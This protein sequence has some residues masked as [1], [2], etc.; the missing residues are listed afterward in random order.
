M[1]VWRVACVW[2]LACELVVFGRKWG[3]G[4]VVGWFLWGGGRGGKGRGEGKGGLR[5]WSGMWLYIV[6]GFG[7]GWL[8]GRSERR[9]LLLKKNVYV[10]PTTKLLEI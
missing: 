6:E 9:V 4:L 8:E 5:W 2:G 3:G 10:K 7:G 1:G